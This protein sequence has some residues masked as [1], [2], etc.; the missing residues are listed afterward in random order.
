MDL[1]S[2]LAHATDLQHV[3]LTEMR[4]LDQSL[5]KRAK[6]CEAHHVENIVSPPRHAQLV[7]RIQVLDNKDKNLW[8]QL[9]DDKSEELYEKGKINVRVRY[10]W[11]WQNPKKS[12]PPKESLYEFNFASYEQVNLVTKFTRP[13][14]IVWLSPSNEASV[15]RQCEKYGYAIVDPVEE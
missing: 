10:T 8:W 13:F 6:S 5:A 15:A 14:Q 3:A 9:P 7:P 4:A 11:H 2:A 1:A 12:I